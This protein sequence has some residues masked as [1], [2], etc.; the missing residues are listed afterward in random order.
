MSTIRVLGNGDGDGDGHDSVFVQELAIPYGG[1]VT[2]AKSQIDAQ[3]NIPLHRL[4]V[5]STSSP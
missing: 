1:D 3:V 4:L 5:L 2:F